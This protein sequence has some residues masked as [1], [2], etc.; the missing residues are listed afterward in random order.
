MPL[1]QVFLH[2]YV[3]INGH[4]RRKAKVT[5]RF[6]CLR[7][8]FYYLYRQENDLL[9]VKRNE[10]CFHVPIIMRMHVT[11][12]QA[13]NRST[14]ICLR[15]YKIE[16]QNKFIFIAHSMNVCVSMKPQVVP[17]HNNNNEIYATIRIDVDCKLTNHSNWIY[18]KMHLNHVLHACPHRNAFDYQYAGSSA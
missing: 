12:N 9:V 2:I 6:F 15:W 7:L 13:F 18:I 3:S 1:S 4:F 10:T 11:L 16:R 8:P 17:T 5:L 14:V